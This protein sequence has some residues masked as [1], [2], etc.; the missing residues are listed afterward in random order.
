ML[1]TNAEKKRE[2]KDEEIKRSKE[3]DGI[4][5]Y[6]YINVEGMIIFFVIHARYLSL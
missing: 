2:T 5:I 4:Y 1:Q 3:R 6:I